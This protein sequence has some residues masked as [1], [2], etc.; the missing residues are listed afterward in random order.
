M[1]YFFKKIICCDITG[2]VL[3]LLPSQN[4]YVHGRHEG[5]IVFENLHD[6][7]V[8][9]TLKVFGG[10]FRMLFAKQIISNK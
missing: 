10:M 7:L 2:F 1:K 5:N 9:N 6:S 8:I 3:F 4:P